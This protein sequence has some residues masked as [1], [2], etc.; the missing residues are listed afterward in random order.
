[1][2]SLLAKIILIPVVLIGSFFHKDEIAKVSLPVTTRAEIQQMVSD[3]LAGQSAVTFGNDT[4]PINGSTYNIS[5]SGVTS[6]ATSF[7]LSSLTIPQNG[8]KIVDADASATFYMTLE[9]GSRTR[10][11]VVSCTTIVQNVAGTA[12]ISGCTRGL[13]PISPYTASTTL[14]FA[15]PGGSQ[16]IFGNA[17]QLFNE[18]AG[19]LNAETITGLWTYPSVDATRARIDADT[20]TAVTTA[21]VTFGQLS[22]QAISGASNGSETI[23]GIFEAATAIEQASST[24]L[25]ST[26]ALL[27]LRALYATSSPLT[28][29]NGTLTIGA[30]CTVV[31]QNN[32]KI[33]Q[34]FLDLSQSFN[35]TG[36]IFA[37][38]TGNFIASSTEYT[39]NVGT[40]NATS[41]IK[42]NGVALVTPTTV[43]HY[44]MI[45]INGLVSGGPY[46]TS[47]PLTIPAG[48]LTASSTIDITFNDD[49]NNAT[50]KASLVDVNGAPICRYVGISGGTINYTAIVRMQIFGNNSSSSQKCMITG[51]DTQYNGAA[52][53]GSNLTFAQTDT[54]SKDFTT[55]QTFYLVRNAGG[56]GL[57][58]MRFTIVITP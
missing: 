36:A 56:G 30:L 1:M 23:K 2:K 45:D 22:R 52:T 47:S 39:L 46:A 7:N 40:I 34:T 16:V 13:S 27:T 5:G 48:V 8:Y 55:A 31:T 57:D 44:N 21:F 15:H 29:C 18:Y 51:V 24:S 17:A 50:C 9:P 33:H 20:D 6:A 26:S 19:K 38:S 11:E 32:G 58:T 4:L 28:G 12:T 25:G 14:K 3:A 35:F 37:S 49:C 42:V 10:Q 53:I 43:P 54:S 41:S